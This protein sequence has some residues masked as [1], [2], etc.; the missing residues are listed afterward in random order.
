[1]TTLI[2][3]S[4]LL[5]Y[6]THVI[7]DSK[8][9]TSLFHKYRQKPIEITALHLKGGKRFREEEEVTG[10]RSGNCLAQHRLQELFK[11]P[12]FYFLLQGYCVEYTVK[13][14]VRLQLNA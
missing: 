3:F 4:I 9:F 10:V 6:E 7:N 5:I 8:N 13:H 14:P 1:M 11:G 12:K 2:N